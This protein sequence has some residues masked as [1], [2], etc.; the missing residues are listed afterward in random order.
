MPNFYD[1][2][3]DGQA[4]FQSNFG[5][6]FMVIIL[7]LDLTFFKLGSKQKSCFNSFTGLLIMANVYR[8]F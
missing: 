2:H 8:S 5:R 3:N 1:D 4:S 6:T 7:E